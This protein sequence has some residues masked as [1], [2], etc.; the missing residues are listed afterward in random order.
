[1]PLNATARSFKRIVRA[2]DSGLRDTLGRLHAVVAGID[3]EDLHNHDHSAN[4][5]EYAVAVGRALGFDAERLV[6]LQRAAF[7]HDIGKASVSPAI[8]AKRGPLTDDEVALMRLHPVAGAA[9]LHAAGLHDESHWVR[10]HHERADGRGYPDGL[11]GDEIPLEA[12]ILQVVDS[13]EAMTSDRPYRPG[14]AVRDA[15]IELRRGAGGQFDPVV[16]AALAGLIEGGAMRV[17]ALRSDT[18]AG[19]GG[20]T[21]LRRPLVLRR[22]G[23]YV[24]QVC[25]P[26][27]GARVGRA[28]PGG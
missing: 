7:L 16:V 12:S 9:V 3:A 17:R 5:A 22:R 1:V 24:G 20:H 26:T 2:A 11:A 8:L 28:P 10:A 15:L 14:M 13:F 21:P 25:E 27:V 6:K 23:R 4:V 19:R 18:T